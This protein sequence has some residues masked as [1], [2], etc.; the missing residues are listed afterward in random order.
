MAE[1]VLAWQGA[2]KVWEMRRTYLPQEVLDSVDFSK[3]RYRSMPV[4]AKTRKKLKPKCTFP[5]ENL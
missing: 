4:N 3:M 2:E 1:K 5:M